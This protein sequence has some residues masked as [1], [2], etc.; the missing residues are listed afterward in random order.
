MKIN[1]K[2]IDDV[3]HDVLV[4]H[5]RGLLEIVPAYMP[6]GFVNEGRKPPE[7]YESYVC[8]DVLG[9]ELLWMN[10]QFPQEQYTWYIWFESIFLVTPE[11]ASYLK[12]KWS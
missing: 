4:D 9:E 10:E 2:S 7:G 11:M 8:V 1:F 6:D 5:F 3:A 12:L